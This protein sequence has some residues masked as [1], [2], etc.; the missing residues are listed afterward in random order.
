MKEMSQIREKNRISVFVERESNTQNRHKRYNEL[1]D[2]VYFEWMNNG[3]NGMT[4]A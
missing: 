2:S 3:L 1:C 4:N